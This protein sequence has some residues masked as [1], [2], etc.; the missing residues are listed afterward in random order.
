MPLFIL[1]LFT[2]IGCSGP[3][4]T[5]DP[6]GPAARE[7]S[8][9]WW[10]MFIYS[11]IIVVGIVALWLYAMRPKLQENQ[12]NR[13]HRALIISGGILL[14]SVSIIL[15]LIFGIP[16][17]HRAQPLPVHGEQPLKIEVI[18]HQWWW[19]IHYP[20]ERIKL[21]NELHLPVGRAID[22]YATSQ[23]V[24]HS[25]WIP[26]L[27]GKIDMIPGYTNIM[28]LQ[29]TKAGFFRAQCAEFCGK[30]HAQMLLKVYAHNSQDFVSWASSKQTAL[31]QVTPQAKQGR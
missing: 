30:F 1:F 19:E 31:I 7:I 21:I 2:V 24:I 17:G 5:L 22:I 15:L 10:G 11:S 18:G 20:N 16:V 3:Q 14:P 9:L 12:S 28:R 27:S 4:S 8:Y 13:S 26:R 6:A 23:D 29:V 25:F